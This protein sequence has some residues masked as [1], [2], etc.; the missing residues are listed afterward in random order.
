MKPLR[1]ED[2]P[3]RDNPIESL[4]AGEHDILHEVAFKRM[5]AIECKR[6]ERRK[7]PFLLMLAEVG[8]DPLSRDSREV[9]ER[10]M[11]V[12][13][14]SSRET[15]VLGWYKAHSVIGVMFTGLTVTDKS[16][17][18]TTILARVSAV[19]RHELS[20]EQFNQ[21]SLS[22]HLFPDD[23]DRGSADGP[24]DSALYPDRATPGASKRA[25]LHFKRIIDEVGSGL[26]P[27]L[28]SA[29]GG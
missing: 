11:L 4:P 17:I 2:F 26:G 8:S 23:W 27:L 14:A 28:L 7:E 3:R 25:P 16:L 12:L 10:M 19:L 15:D 20:L 29:D 6:S 5:I 18:L 22:F 24:T 13:Q 1:V 9:L 21:V